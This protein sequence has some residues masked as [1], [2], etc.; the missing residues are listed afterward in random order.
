MACFRTLLIFRITM[1]QDSKGNTIISDGEGNVV[2]LN[3]TLV[4]NLHAN[5]FILL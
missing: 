5:D 3:H 1:S 2:T 4:A